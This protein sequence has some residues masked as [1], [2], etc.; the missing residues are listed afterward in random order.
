[1]TQLRKAREGV[2]T[3][4]IEYIAGKEEIDPSSL[5]EMWPKEGW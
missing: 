5:G 1:M 4:E 3:P 2:L